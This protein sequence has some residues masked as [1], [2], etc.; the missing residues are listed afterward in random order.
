MLVD[1]VDDEDEDQRYLIFCLIWRT[2]I[3]IHLNILFF[4]RVTSFFKLWAEI[5]CN[6][7]MVTGVIVNLVKLFDPIHEVLLEHIVYKVFLVILMIIFCYI[8]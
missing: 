5:L 1:K 4:K 2:A 6:V 3:I 8:N 7:L